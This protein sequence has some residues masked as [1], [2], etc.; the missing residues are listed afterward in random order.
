MKNRY[1]GLGVILVTLLTFMMT[2]GAMAEEQSYVPDDMSCPTG[3][4]EAPEVYTVDVPR[5]ELPAGISLYGL[6]P[7]ERDILLEVSSMI[8]EALLEGE[9]TIYL[10]PYSLLKDDY[11]TLLGIR[12]YCPYIDGNLVKATVYI[13]GSSPVYIYSIELTVNA[14][15]AQLTE[16]FERIDQKLAYYRQAAAKGSNDMEK[17]LLLHDEIAD[18]CS[19]DYSLIPESHYSGYMLLNDTGVCQAYANLYAYLLHTMG[20]ECYLV[21]STAMNHEWN[22]VELDGACYHVDIT[23]DD[24]S[25][26]R[27]PGAIGHGYFLVSDSAFTEVRGGTKN[28][29]SWESLVACNATKYDNAFWWGSN[30]GALSRIL[31]LDNQAYFMEKDGLKSVSMETGAK[32][33]LVGLSRTYVFGANSYYARNF[34]ALFYWDGRIYYSTPTSVVAYDPQTGAKETVY[35]I[36]PQSEQGYLYGLSR[37][38]RDILYAIKADANTDGRTVRVEAFLTEE[39]AE[40]PSLSG[41]I[42]GMSL[43]MYA[44]ARLGMNFYI[45]ING[46]PA[47]YT[48]HYAVKGSE[49]SLTGVLSELGTPSVISGEELFLLQ[50]PL[51]ACELSAD[52]YVSLSVGNELL[53]EVSVSGAEYAALI[54]NDPAYREVRDMTVA[55]MNFAAASQAY[56]KKNT[57]R[58]ANSFLSEADRSLPA[59]DDAV[60]ARYRSF[61]PYGDGRLFYYGSSLI[62]DSAITIRHYFTTESGFVNGSYRFQKD[63]GLLTTHRKGELLYVECPD[64]DYFTLEAAENVR[65]EAENAAWEEMEYPVMRYI[66]MVCDRGVEDELTNLVRAMYALSVSRAL[67]R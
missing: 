11:P 37:S 46:S 14:S 45:A 28:H 7:S 19:Y 60:L 61:R 20:M 57:E 67:A 35:T 2:C 44:D 6:K 27:Y 49:T 29:H 26:G 62:L 47:E 51:T 4:L 23:W 42:R 36:D 53:D 16:M 22:A 24:T 48:V 40:E 65:I 59:I 50:I 30:G 33:T 66:A 64:I 5:G 25:A 15:K 55:M 9:R 41:L 63:G 8:K 31:L 32:T 58:P 18:T 13:T 43:S 12:S 17:L 54:I 38:G 52:I 56:F 1:W 21:D 3:G 34:S 10:L 39:E